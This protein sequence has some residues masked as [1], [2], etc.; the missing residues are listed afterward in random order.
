[1]IAATFRGSSRYHFWLYPFEVDRLAYRPSRPEIHPVVAVSWQ[2]ALVRKAA[3]L[4][5]PIRQSALPGTANSWRPWSDFE[6]P[7]DAERSLFAIILRSTQTSS[8]PSF[9]ANVK[10]GLS[11]EWRTVFQAA[12]A[13][14]YSPRQN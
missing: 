5:I 10:R 11:R 8:S 14:G 1:M 9:A 13:T 12:A 4:V 7:P 6:C 3:E 2:A